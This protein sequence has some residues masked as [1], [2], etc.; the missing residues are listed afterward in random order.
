M[1]E[2][3]DAMF[4]TPKEEL[5]KSAE[6]REEYTYPFV[7]KPTKDNIVYM[8]STTLMTQDPDSGMP[9]HGSTPRKT[10]TIGFVEEICPETIRFV[11]SF[12]TIDKHLKLKL[13]GEYRIAGDVGSIG[14]LSAMPSGMQILP[15]WHLLE[16]Q[17]TDCSKMEPCESGDEFMLKDYLV[18][19]A[20]GHVPNVPW[21]DIYTLSVNFYYSKEDDAVAFMQFSL[22]ALQYQEWV[23]FTKA[24]LHTMLY[25]N[26]ECSKED[27]MKARPVVYPALYKNSESPCAKKTFSL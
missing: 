19:T 15:T 9:S 5:K 27:D 10:F 11:A 17:S 1:H 23:W 12:N 7:W 24:R 21:Q 14:H 13:D 8:G 2:E 20:K 25:G 3:V 22:S 18:F 4:R 16:I 6:E 26:S